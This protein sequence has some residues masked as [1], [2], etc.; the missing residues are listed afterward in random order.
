M[1]KLILIGILLALGLILWAQNQSVTVVS[2]NGGE[3]WQTGNTYPITWLAVNTAVDVMIQL[4]RSNPNQPIL[5]IASNIPAANGVYHWII[6]TAIPSATDYKVRISLNA[7]TGTIGYDH[8]DDFFSITANTNPPQPSI[9]VLSPNGGEVWTAG[10]TATI[11]WTSQNLTGNVK[12]SLERPNMFTD[13][14]VAPSVPI[15]S[16]SLTWLVPPDILPA[17][18][19][20]VHIVWISVLTVYIADLSDN[21][22]SIVGDGPP[23]PPPPVPLTLISP[24]GGENWVKGTMHP[25]TW[26]HNNL[27]G[28]VMLHL[29]AM[30]NAQP[31]ITLA[32]NIPVQAGSFNWNIPTT[33]PAGAHYIVRI[34]QATPDG[35]LI[36][37]VSDAVFTISDSGGGNLITVVSPNGGEVWQKGMA[38]PIQWISP[39]T[40]IS[41]E[42]ALMRG[43]DMMQPFRV[44]ASNVP[45]TGEFIWLIPPDVP[46]GP[47]Y[48]IRV[49]ILANTMI[50][51]LSDGFFSIIEPMPPPSGITVTCPNGGEVWTKGTTQTITWSA[52]DLNGPVRIILVRNPGSNRRI[53]V[54]ARNV[55][56]TGSYDWTIPMRITP[57]NRF[58][59]AVVSVIDHHLRDLSDQFFAIVSPDVVFSASPNPARDKTTLCFEVEVPT[60]AEI[61]IYNIKGQ[62]IRTLMEPRTI[63]GMQNLIWDG[64]DRRGNPVSAGVYFARL[65]TPDQTFTTRIMIM[66]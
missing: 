66:K 15:E 29:I 41:G 45:L 8:S 16:G 11:T 53:F 51:D 27:T 48:K 4:V 6:P 19:Y 42:I 13:I 32:S 24:N 55:P 33:I 3:N 60:S 34:S 37:D 31:I 7:F 12:I 39:A 35:V 36:Q 22:F 23:P 17:D 56:N 52:P 28:S 64:K 26:L 18:D 20:K 10:T 43:D 54:I 40:T 2:P 58:K 14:V 9:T 30:N 63:T 5:T 47:D 44:I 65:T 1:R 62:K 38:Y 25:I 59:I 49:R 61:S 21:C 57:G 50:Y 46:P